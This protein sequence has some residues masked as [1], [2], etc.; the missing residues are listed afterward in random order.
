MKKDIFEMKVKF[1]KWCMENDKQASEETFGEFLQNYEKEII[2]NSK[3]SLAELVEQNEELKVKVDGVFGFLL[4]EEENGEA[5]M[6]HFGVGH[7]HK[8][9]L[10]KALLV[11]ANHLLLEDKLDVQDVTIDMI[12]PIQMMFAAMIRTL[13]GKEKEDKEDKVDSKHI[14]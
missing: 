13:F 2:E 14:C 12:E 11:M 10:A 9:H 4:T 6:N 5:L 8:S 3:I 1:L 7:A